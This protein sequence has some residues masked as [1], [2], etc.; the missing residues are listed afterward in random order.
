MAARINKIRHD[1]E[2]RL[3]I[4]TSQLINRLQDHVLGDLDLKPTQVQSAL[5]LLK[6]TI[7]DLSQSDTTITNIVVRELSDNE[8]TSIA[9]GSS[10]GTAEP[11]LDPS[12]LN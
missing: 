2:T 12:Q 1:D 4:K 10:D 6:K 9:A 8:L 5:G 11:S 7:P 3:K